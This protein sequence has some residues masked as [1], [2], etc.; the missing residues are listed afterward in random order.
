MRFTGMKTRH[1]PRANRS[2]AFSLLVP[3]AVRAVRAVRAVVAA[4]ARAAV[5]AVCAV[6]AAPAP[7]VV[8]AVRAVVAAPAR[9]VVLALVA[10][11]AVAAVALPQAAQAQ[12]VDFTITGTDRNTQAG[13]VGLQLY[14]GDTFTVTVT[15]SSHLTGGMLDTVVTIVTGADDITTTGTTA[16][17]GTRT[18][19]RFR[20]TPTNRSVSQTWTVTDDNVRET[21][22]ESVE[23]RLWG[24][25]SA[26]VDAS[27]A[28]PSTGW[29]VA[30]GATGRLRNFGI[31]A[32]D[33][34][35]INVA[36]GAG[37]DNT[38]VREGGPSRGHRFVLTRTGDAIT[39][40]STAGLYWYID[41]SGG[42][43]SHA[44]F[45]GLVEVGG[46]G[47]GRMGQAL[48]GVTA[49]TIP[50]SGATHFFDVQ[51]NDDADIE[52]TPETFTLRIGSTVLGSET[53]YGSVDLTITDNDGYTLS[54]RN[55]FNTTGTVTGA[56]F[57]VSEGANEANRQ[58]RIQ[59][60]A[61]DNSSAL[62]AAATVTATIVGEAPGITTTNS[63]YPA[64]LTSERAATATG[65]GADF[66]SDSFMCTIP[67]NTA[68][69][70]IVLCAMPAITDDTVS[71]RAEHFT[72]ALSGGPT[73][74]TYGAKQRLFIHP[75]D[76]ITMNVESAAVSASEGEAATVRVT[77][78]AVAG[79]TVQDDD[80]TVEQFRILFDD[81]NE[82]LSG[83][84]LAANYRLEWPAAANDTSLLDG[85]PIWA[86]AANARHT[87]VMI[88]TMED[89]TVEANEVL[90]YR[91]R[92]FHDLPVAFVITGGD[93]GDDGTFTVTVVDDDAAEWTVRA[94]AGGVL[95]ANVNEGAA[96]IATATTADTTSDNV[97]YFRFT[98]YEG[99]NT[100][101]PVTVTYC[102]GGT[103][104]GVTQAAL[105][106]DSSLPYD[107]IYPT[108]Y[109]PTDTSAAHTGYQGDC[110][111]GRGT[112]S[113]A[114]DTEPH[115]RL[116]FAINDDDLNEPAET[117][118]ASVVN[119][120]ETGGAATVDDTEAETTAT[121]TI[122]ASDPIT[123]SIANAGVDADDDTDGFQVGEGNNARFT[124]TL[125]GGRR[126]TNV[127]VMYSISGD[128]V[129]ADYTDSGSGA[130][131][132]APADNSGEISIALASDADTA[133]EALTV[134]INESGH[135]SAGPLNR[136]ATN[137]A[138]TQNVITQTV[139][140]TL[141]LVRLDGAGTDAMPLSTPPT[142]YAEDAG[143]VY[144]MVN[145]ADVTPPA[146]AAAQT[147]TWTVTHAGS[148][149]TDADDFTG[150]TTGTLTFPTSGC[151]ASV[152]TCRFTVTINDDSLDENTREG[153]SVALSVADAT[154]DGGINV[155][156]GSGALTITDNDRTTV[157][158]STA[159]AAVSEGGNAVVSVRLSTPADRQVTI[160]YSATSGTLSGLGST[161]ATSDVDA[162]L[163]GAGAD[164]GAI[165]IG[166]TVAAATAGTTVTFDAGQTVASLTLPSF[167]RLPCD[168]MA[169]FT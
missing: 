78:S 120:V 6:V 164:R 151:S 131:T 152:A 5:R 26:A 67:A 39:Q 93:S 48:S 10:F 169:G 7:A 119:V 111:M 19:I 42:T 144:F 103:A 79:T 16:T 12:S 80:A 110:T 106:A 60:E 115:Y 50:T 68:D 4:P 88:P 43:A 108:G 86:R 127:V 35:T 21:G 132:I 17:I 167:A 23:I 58:I 155:G 85:T 91:L 101:G 94:R 20:L 77:F 105:T 163:P 92:G 63:G 2:G 18:G 38:P 113:I 51:I 71:E 34:R 44:D 145:Q 117:I 29:S 57:G 76:A 150:A 107:Y 147:I 24:G 158:V 100:R 134:T 154:A 81:G 53:D 95:T 96:A 148:N 112:F 32:S 118:T 66:A 22:R 129:A 13:A 15:A 143:A 122:V 1:H 168:I 31:E 165:R 123:A 114:A 30:G 49:S 3:A 139:Q 135:T 102:L 41:V 28:T 25:A 54:V 47:S 9:A 36:L 133:S 98:N 140:H 62:A 90:T 89:T 141:A 159:A 70:A 65:T 8:R 45:T 162:T 74:A 27:A 161:V 33:V 55:G 157:N 97:M 72:V 136:H 142:A 56:N 124:V 64:G 73:G 126:T 121:R 137:N 153:F 14:E 146:F 69:D 128:V 40:G 160:D 166:A 125:T 149:G 109:D 104:I 83:N 156:T 99:V 11:A 87:D 37:A 82:P 138:A 84:T 59:Y 130:L 75:S 61:N 116:G 52:T 46:S